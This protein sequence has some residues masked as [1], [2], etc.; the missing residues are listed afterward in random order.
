MGAQNNNRTGG[1]NWL[2]TEEAILRE[3]W[4]AG[5]S[6]AEI[7]RVLA[8]R[9]RNSVIGRVHR[10]GLTREQRQ[11]PAAPKV[12]RIKAAP[13]PPKPGPQNKP[14][15]IFGAAT[16]LSPEETAKR[17]SEQRA[18]GA[19]IIEDFKAPANDT[20]IPLMQRGRRQCSWPVGIP[21][22]P[23]RQLC[24]GQRVKLGANPAV[25]SYCPSH[26][27]AAMARKPGMAAPS[28]KKFERSLR[29]YAA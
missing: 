5:W 7:S 8:G 21:D 10:L 26:A 23:A 3:K 20:A 6:A 15:V 24:C 16:V 1:G 27:A 28:V 9:S 25:E 11:Q 17:Q 13:K 29:R 14:A 2:P 18:H 22:R 19:K 12:E 4:S